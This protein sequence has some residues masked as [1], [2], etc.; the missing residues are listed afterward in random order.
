MPS[1]LASLLVP[2]LAT[3]LALA[4]SLEEP[5]TTQRP[6][7]CNDSELQEARTLLRNA[8]ARMGTTLPESIPVA[9]VTSS[10][11]ML[12]NGT[13][14]P[15]LLTDVNVSAQHAVCRND[16]R[17]FPFVIGVG[18][19]ARGRN[20]VGGRVTTRYGTAKASRSN[21]GFPSGYRQ[22]ETRRFIMLLIIPG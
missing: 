9:G 19:L 8:V 5:P 21:R 10:G 14:A 12:Y 2:L 20:L 15:L 7:L 1:L 6:D 22:I 16:V 3:S 17:H 13:L 4:Q 11:Y 18:T